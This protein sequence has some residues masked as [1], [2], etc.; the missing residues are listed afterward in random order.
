MIDTKGKVT[1]SFDCEGRWGMADR[2]HAWLSE[3]TNNN[4]AEVYE[5]ILE[6]LKRYNIAATFAFVGALTET[7]ENFLKNALPQLTGTNHQK[8]IKPI[9]K[10]I[11]KNE[12][13]FIPEVFELVRGSHIHECASH[14]YTHTPFSCLDPSEFKTEMNLIKQW[15]IGKNIEC[16]TL[17][18]PRNDIK[19]SNL[20]K[21]YGIELYR[22]PPKLFYIKSFPKYLNT[23]FEEL[24]IFKKSEALDLDKFSIPGGV[25]INWKYGPRKMIPRMI[26]D[27]RYKNILNHAVKRSN[28]AH[29]WIHP[30]NF[31]TAPESKV[32]FEKLCHQ[33]QN[34]VEL[35]QLEVHRQVDF[36]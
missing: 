9:L 6:T 35:N 27:L 30:H 16:K 20:I 31:I 25:F 5:Y 13:W 18:Y 26:S 11:D 2:N 24:N 32:I 29:F 12:G 7:K 21:N 4:L 23:F 28:V 3:L 8:W 19:Y 33:I 1:L 10:S 14:G 15:S 22:K 17:I 36:I 34:K